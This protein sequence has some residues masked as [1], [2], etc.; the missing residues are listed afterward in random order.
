MERSEKRSMLKGIA[1]EEGWEVI[2]TKF[3]PTNEL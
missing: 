2:L 3:W 1:E